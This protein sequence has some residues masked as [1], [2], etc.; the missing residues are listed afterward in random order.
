[1]NTENERMS[2]E[3]EKR[4]YNRLYNAELSRPRSCE[5]LIQLRASDPSRERYR[6]LHVCVYELAAE[7]ERLSDEVKADW[8]VSPSASQGRITL[9]LI[10]YDT[11]EEA[12][13]V[14][15]RA[16]THLGLD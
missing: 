6:R 13:R 2:P 10:S 11:A 14:A 12:S 9:E 4:F 7:I 8:V 5:W 16:L 15:K 1:M 3:G